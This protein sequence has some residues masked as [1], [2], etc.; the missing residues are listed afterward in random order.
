MLPIH[1]RPLLTFRSQDDVVRQVGPRPAL[2]Q[3]IL[4]LVMF[5][6]CPS[7]VTRKSVLAAGP[8]PTWCLETPKG[9]TEP[10]EMAPTHAKRICNAKYQKINQLL[11]KQ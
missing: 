2:R 9:A 10:P 4:A 5:D 7:A 1:L 8:V 6:F 11:R 3:I